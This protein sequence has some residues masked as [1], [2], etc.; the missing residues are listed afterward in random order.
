MAV[1]RVINPAKIMQELLRVAA[2]ARVSSDSADQIHS[3]IAQINYYTKYINERPDWSLVD[4]YADEGLTG[5]KIDK[6]ND[7]IRL[8]EDCKKGKIDRIITKSIPRFARNHYECISTIRLLKEYG[9][10]V[11]FEEEDIDTDTMSS[12]L[13]LSMGAIL[14]EQGSMSISKNMRWSCRGRMETG[15]YINA[16]PAYGYK[17]ENKIMIPNNQGEEV[18]HRIFDMFLSGSGKQT[19][20]NILISEKIPQKNGKVEWHR[21]TVDYILN[22]ERYIGDALLQKSYTTNA[23][24]F[25]RKRNRGELPQYYIEND[26]VPILNKK[27]FESA[28]KLQEV[29]KRNHCLQIIYPLSRKLICPDCGHLFR[30]I[31]I[32][33][34]P[35]WRCAYASSGKRNCTG[36]SLPETQIYDAFILMVNKLTDNKEQ[37]LIPMIEQLEK[38]QSRLS[39]TQNK[40]YLIDKE[41]ANLN[42]QNLMIV[43]LY[44][45]E[46]LSPADYTEQSNEINKKVSQLR[47]DRRRLLQQDENDEMLNGLQELNQILSEIT[48]PQTEFDKE[49]FAD[50]VQNIS[51][52]SNTSLQFKL[53]GG[54]ELV[55]TIPYKERRRVG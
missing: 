31:I 4:I 55:E 13:V 47:S 2:Y 19:I 16:P 44:N 1:I 21:S 9:V 27:V 45:N 29:K 42:N 51:V 34:K 24:P 54:L 48:Q 39:G 43:R 6:R 17:L 11:Y 37:I 15:E 38:M 26:H 50:I 3:F 32:N 25:Q 7:F 18:V 14:A 20:A 30:R 8:I 10:S 41:I 35:Y 49:L 23:F 5:T 28:Q 52:Q 33:N 40:I 12:E 46:I 53:I 22:N 36:I